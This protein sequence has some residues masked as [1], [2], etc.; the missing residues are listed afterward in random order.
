MWKLVKASVSFICG[1][2]EVPVSVF[3]TLRLH[4][5]KEYSWTRTSP[6][7]T[8]S[9]IQMFAKW[10]LFGGKSFPVIHIL[11]QQWMFILNFLVCLKLRL[12]T[13]RN[14]FVSTFGSWWCHRLETPPTCPSNLLF[15]TVS[16]SVQSWPK[17]EGLVSDRGETEALHRGPVWDKEG[18][19][20]AVSHAKLL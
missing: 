2:A 9:M 12:Q 16:Q 5:H 8:E 6:K 14:T 15:V 7:S 17:G 4:L 18:L 20:L 10:V 19:F 1:Q 3:S 13:A 11:F